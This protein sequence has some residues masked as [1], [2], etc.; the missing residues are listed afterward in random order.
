MTL[1]TKQK[2]TQTYTRNIWLTKGKWGGYIGSMELTAIF[3]KRR[4]ING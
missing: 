2:Q 1:Y 4:H 3:L